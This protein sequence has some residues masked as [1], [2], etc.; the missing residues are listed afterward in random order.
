MS[1]KPRQHYISRF[2]IKQ[3]ADG[4]GQVGVVCLHHRRSATVSADGLHW[5][6]DL[7]SPAQES[8][9][10]KT[11]SRASRVID[12]LMQSLGPHTGDLAAAER[13]VAES[14]NL[15]ALVD[16][17]AL[18]HARSLAVPLQQFMDGHKTA[19]SSAAEATIRA[20]RAEAQ[21]YYQCGAVVSVLPAQTPVPLGAIPVFNTADWGGP[22][23]GTSAQFLMPLT[24]RVVIAGNPA[25]Q[26]G[27]VKVIAESPAQPSLLW[28][29]IAGELKQFGTPYLICEPSALEQTASEALSATVGTAMHWHALH[30]RVD[31][32]ASNVD[33]RLRAD[34]RKRVQC[35]EHL[36]GWHTDPTTTNAMKEKH[37]NAMIEGAQELQASFDAH[38][39][40]I[41]SCRWLYHD[42]A[43]EVKAL[44]KRFMPQ[45][46]CDAMQK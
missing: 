20:R 24:P 35:H 12:G 38:G 1:R 21:S 8:E 30:N 14:T 40:P 29:Q 3:W 36:Q 6:R 28:W 46:I 33:G 25:M 27:E 5:V 26:P 9:W 15:A 39:I 17:V 34:W 18:H 4:A 43:P 7:S 42:A 23:L 22:L 32:Y 44:W 16:L 10:N 11:E 31:R 13:F 37:R 45:I 41:C 2:L 19:D